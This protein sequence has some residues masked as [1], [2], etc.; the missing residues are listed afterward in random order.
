MKTR[1]KPF[2]NAELFRL[3]WEML[4]T[5]PDTE[6]DFGM[7]DYGIASG[8][9]VPISNYQWDTIGIV[10]FGGSE[11]IYLD[12][13]ADGIVDASGIR[14]RVPFGTF[15]TLRD[16]KTAFGLMGVLNADFVYAMRHFLNEH[17]DD[18]EW[19]GFNVRFYDRKRDDY[20]F[21]YSSFTTL[22]AVKARIIRDMKSGRYIVDRIIVCDNAKCLYAEFDPKT[23]DDDLVKRLMDADYETLEWVLG[24]PLS[25]FVLENLEARLKETVPLL[26]EDR[27]ECLLRIWKPE[28]KSQE[29]YQ[30]DRECEKLW[31]ELAD[32]P[33]DENDDGEL[34]LSKPWHI[35]EKGAARED[36]WMWFDENYSK[37]VYALLYK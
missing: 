9:V 36:V 12:L 23:S 18:F 3:I 10:N 17:L 26:N 5:E 28:W 30:K 32:I 21:G 37:G 15:K 22:E 7:L 34:I 35:F 1:M 16:D 29:V 33:F 13:Y 20:L 4:K 11:G 25:D 27:I 19:T 8:D 2:T 24:Y 6:F 31:D 14:K